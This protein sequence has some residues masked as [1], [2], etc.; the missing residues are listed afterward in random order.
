VKI[1]SMYAVGAAF[2]VLCV[3]GY[4]FYSY[5]ANESSAQTHVAEIPCNQATW[6]NRSEFDAVTW[7]AGRDREKFVSLL[8]AS[9]PGKTREHVKANLGTPANDPAAEPNYY[10]YLIGRYDFMRCDMAISAWLVIY[11]DKQ[12]KVTS[13][14][15]NKVH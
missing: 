15:L 10:R 2:L 13:V 8:I 9:L 7:Q 12:S 11:F 4:L 14:S 6:E 5:T 3:T 1:R